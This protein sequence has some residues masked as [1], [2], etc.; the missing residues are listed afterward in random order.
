M[1]P[2]PPQIRNVALVGHK[3]AGKTA[4]VEAML[5]VARAA[6][7]IPSGLCDDTP[8][9]RAHGTTLESRLVRLQWGDTL[10]NLIDT[11]GEATLHAEAQMALAAAD[12]ALLIISATGGVES[13]TE[14]A[15]RW[16]HEANLPALAVLTK[17]D[18]EGARVE[19]VV[20]QAHDRFKEPVDAMEVAVGGPG[21]RYRGVA[22]V[23]PPKA[24]VGAPEGPSAVPSPVPPE[25]APALA[26]TRAHLVDDVAG[27]DDALTDKFLEKGDLTP[28]EL[29][30]GLHADVAE[31]KLLPVFFASSLTP[32]GIVA[33]LDAIA[34]L[35]PPPAPALDGPLAAFVWKTHIH[36]HIG[37]ISFARVR[38]GVLRGDARLANG[39]DGNKE[40]VGQLLQGI[41]REL[42]PVA[43][44][45]AGDIV[46]VSKLKTTRTG[47]TLCDEKHPV[48]LP[49]PRLMPPLYAR[50]LLADARGK[51]DKLGAAVARLAEEDPGLV[52]THDETGHELVV[53]GGG[54]LHLEITLERLSRRS[55]LTAHLGPPRIAYRETVTRAVTRVEGKQK[56]QT[57][58][59]GQFGVCQIDIEPLPRGAGFEFEDAI[60]GGVIPR[61]FIPSVEKGVRRALE[62]GGLAG[63]PVVDVKVRLVD[64]KAHSVDSSDAAFQ[65]AGFKAFR[66]A[67]AAAH[68]V[69]L[70]PIVKLRVHVP[71]ASTGDAIGD[72]NARRGK[73]L[74][75]EAED[76]STVIS[77][78]VPLSETL[79]YEPKLASLTQG[80]GTFELAPDHY[81]FCPGH[82]Q[83]RV[84]A[85]SGYQ[86][87]EED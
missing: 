69:L 52:L 72:L 48:T 78:W 14:R 77:A 20:A 40:R 5:Y 12:A 50:A 41:G 24:W 9:E 16:L 26:A 80:K 35:V 84:I 42:K 18:E 53:A 82:V 31:S 4:L 28:E 81:D 33:L 21:A 64:G 44:A 83:E 71:G 13:G 10:I 30:A 74:G 61:Q 68:P 56:K 55:G 1:T 25:L 60:V 3:G 34:S 62:R 15:F 58:G 43:E 11:P 51:D 36:P 66:A 85:Q 27:T 7:A 59:H 57:G 73:V 19:E 54:P 76:E 17:V 38:A 87:E 2:R 22:T 49:R 46:A 8:E 70:E 29:D 67:A 32:S 6:S 75:T 65:A 86:R 23:L 47:E 79:D 45:V 63:Y 37:R 39:A